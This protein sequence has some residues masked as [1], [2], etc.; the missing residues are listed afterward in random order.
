[1]CGLVW[2]FK[3]EATLLISVCFLA[4]LFLSPSGAAARVRARVA[5]WTD[6]L[7][8]PVYFATSGLKTS[9]GLLD[10]SWGVFI[11]ILLAATLGKGGACWLA[12]RLDGRPR[13]EALAIGG[14]MNARGLMELVILNLGLAHG[15]I[16]PR[17]FTMM[18]LMAVATTFAAAPIYEWSRRLSPR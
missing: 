7:L 11:L 1:M 16:Q 18:A 6:A 12:A 5:A 13:G 4:G 3:A 17:L 14:L 9:I 8:L 15:L 2:A 10:G